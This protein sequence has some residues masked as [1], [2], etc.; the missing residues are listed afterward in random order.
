MPSY[1]IKT[2]VLAPEEDITR[3]FEGDNPAKLFNVMNEKIRSVFKVGAASFF[4]D[5]IKWDKLG[6]PVEFFGQWRGKDAK[7]Q[8][9]TFW[10]K[11][12]ILGKQNKKDKRGK[13]KIKIKPWLVTKIPYSTTFDK[14]MK[15][16]NMKSFYKKQIKKYVEETSRQVEEFDNELRDLFE[17]EL[18]EVA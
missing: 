13:V 14:A 1:E 5:K 10:V 12:V 4:D 11:V 18:K 7:D 3:E 9:T 2:N 16:I 6:D 8:W 15:N 17:A